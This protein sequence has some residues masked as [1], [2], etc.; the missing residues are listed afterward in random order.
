MK[1]HF[2]TSPDEFRD[3]LDKNHDT[4]TEVFVG[5]Y[6][7]NSGKP[8]ITWPESVDVALCFGWIDGVLKPIDNDSYSRRFTPRKAN[9]TW[10]A[11]NINKMEDL[12]TKKLVR[13]AGMAAYEKRKESN[14]KIYAYEQENPEA[15]PE[16]F[17]KEFKAN[18]GA[19]EFFMKQAPWYRKQMIHRITSAKQEKTKQSRF[20]KLLNASA[21]GKRI[22]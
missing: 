21:E 13:P 3:W 10:S 17:E 6:K 22:A 12:I 11:V 8:S 16:V 4:A 20:E 18:K 5:F 19:W 9:S 7:T 1:P 15:L 2:F 14:S